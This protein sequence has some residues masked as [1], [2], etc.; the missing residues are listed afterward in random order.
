MVLLHENGNLWLISRD[1]APTLASLVPKRKPVFLRLLA[2]SWPWSSWLASS[3]PH[4]VRACIEISAP[5]EPVLVS[6]SFWRSWRRPPRKAWPLAR[7]L[8]V[9]ARDGPYQAGE[10]ATP[11]AAGRQVWV[12]WF[13]ERRQIVKNEVALEQPIEP[14]YEGG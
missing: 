9:D 1:S 13:P 7:V 8:K 11:W 12:P 5:Q 2:P 14:V 4:E 10:G 6:C 3:E